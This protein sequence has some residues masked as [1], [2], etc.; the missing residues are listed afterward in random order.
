MVRILLVDD[1]KDV[2]DSLFEI[3]TS[4]DPRAHIDTA[5]SAREARGCLAEGAYDLVVSDE[6][7]PDETGSELLA[8]VERHH[9]ETVRALMSAAPRATIARTNHG[10]LQKP[11]AFADL[12]ALMGRAAAHQGRPPGL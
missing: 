11:F 10:F 6:R 9:P 3:L 12:Q 7:M 8:W 2:L 4:H 1:E 5:G